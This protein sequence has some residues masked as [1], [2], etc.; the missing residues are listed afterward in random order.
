MQQHCNC[1]R[2][3]STRY[4]CNGFTDGKYGIII[5]IPAKFVVLIP[6]NANVNDNRITQQGVEIVVHATTNETSRYTIGSWKILVVQHPGV[7]RILKTAVVDGFLYP[8]M[9]QTE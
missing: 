2:S 5:H 3:Y 9:Y 4:R 1:H 6:V 7:M 8:I